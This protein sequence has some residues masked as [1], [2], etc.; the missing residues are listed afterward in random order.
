MSCEVRFLLILAV[1]AAQFEPEGSRRM[2]GAEE[3]G[4]DGPPAAEVFSLRVRPL[5]VL[6][7]SALREIFET[8]SVAGFPSHSGILPLT[9]AKQMKRHQ[10]D[11]LSSGKAA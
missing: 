4:G 9:A 3:G 8:I 10:P 11:S 1:L 7:T 6:A 5:P 2:S